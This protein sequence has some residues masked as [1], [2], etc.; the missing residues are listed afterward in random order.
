MYFQNTINPM[1]GEID[2]VPER[3]GM[4]DFWI[5]VDETDFMSL[6]PNYFKK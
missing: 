5:K 1:E 2:F 4:A 6:K 3:D